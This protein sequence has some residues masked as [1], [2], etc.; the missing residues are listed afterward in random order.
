[1]MAILPLVDRGE[2][3]ED[4]P[5]FSVHCSGHGAHV[6]LTASAIERLVNTDHGIELHWRCRCG[7]TGMVITGRGAGREPSAPLPASVTGVVVPAG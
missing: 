3:A 6:L 2:D 4:D 5:M 1:M 7:T